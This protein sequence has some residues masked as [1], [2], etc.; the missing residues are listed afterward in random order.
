MKWYLL[1]GALTL[2]SSCLKQSIPDAMLGSKN[3]GGQNGGGLTATLSY[4]LNGNAVNI[5]VPNADGQNPNYYTLGCTK[6]TGYN[7]DGI[8][9]SGEIT[10]TFYTDSLTLGRYTYTGIYGEMYFLTYNGQSEYVYAA[11]DSMSFTVTSYQHGHISGTFSGRLT[12][13]VSAGN[14]TNTYGAVGSI[15]ISH[16]SFQN[17][18]VFY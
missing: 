1:A 10:F 3:S 12:P 11:T 18:P 17:V 7:L 14:P 9:N 13:L 4:T 2:F 6:S 8:S 15:S 5:S 16:G